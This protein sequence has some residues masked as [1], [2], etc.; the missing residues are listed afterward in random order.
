MR[1]IAVLTLACLAIAGC[2][3]SPS[4]PLTANDAPTPPSLDTIAA[5]LADVPCE[6]DVVGPETTA[7]LL[8]LAD[9]DLT[10]ASGSHGEIDIHDHWLISARLGD[11]GF[12]I[13]D[14]ADPLHPV[15]V[16]NYSQSPSHSYDVKWTTDGQSALVGHRAGIVVVDMRDPLHPVNESAWEFP[17]PAPLL[18]GNTENAHMLYAT[19]VDGRE[20]VL[21]A[22]NTNTGVWILELTGAPGA[23]ELKLLSKFGENI[24]GPLGPHDMWAT[25]DEDLQVPVLYVANGFAGWLAADLSDPAKPV[26][27]GGAL[28]MLDPYQGYTHT[29]Q[30]AKVGDRRLVVTIAEVGL[31]ALKVYDATNLRAPILLGT[32]T[33]KP[34]PIGPEHNLQIVGDQLFVAHYREGMYAFNLSAVA[35][36][37]TPA[38]IAPIAHFAVGPDPQLGLNFGDVWDVVVKDGLIYLSEIDFGVHVVGFGCMQPA[39]GLSSTG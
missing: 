6:V 5:L 21:L 31:N 25:F 12:D 34:V 10:G 3:G 24:N 28:P 19:N 16:G 35:P 26:M 2:I 8:G 30:A 9:L 17:K 32:W 23:R 13:L 22:P 27:L 20:I 4:S 29:I 37:P 7:N 11:S 1:G 15:V 18:F 39:P 36:L 38:G 33:S 14:I